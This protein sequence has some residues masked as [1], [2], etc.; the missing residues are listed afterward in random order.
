M[1]VGVLPQTRPSANPLEATIITR[2]PHYGLEPQ[3][4]HHHHPRPSLRAKTRNPYTIIAQAIDYSFAG[5]QMTTMPVFR[6]VS[7]CGD[8]NDD[9][10]K[11]V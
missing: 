7:I 5:T 4:L 1:P 9:N 3:S 8:A 6:L 11:F 10:E 2:V